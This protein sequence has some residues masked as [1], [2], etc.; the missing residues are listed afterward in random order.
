ME[1]AFLLRG[2][3]SHLKALSVSQE[4]IFTMVSV[5]SITFLRNVCVN[6][7]LAFKEVWQVHEKDDGSS[8]LISVSSFQGT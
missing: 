7:I 1:S 8:M 2:D 6:G 3:S 5:T 4:S